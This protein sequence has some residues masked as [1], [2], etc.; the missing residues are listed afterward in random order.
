MHYISSYVSND[1]LHMPCYNYLLQTTVKL[2]PGAFVLYL[3][4]YSVPSYPHARKKHHHVLLF[5]G[6]AEDTNKAQTWY[7]GV[8]ERSGQSEVSY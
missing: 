1:I 4:S 5:M 7:T 6:D 2:K 3:V 8:P